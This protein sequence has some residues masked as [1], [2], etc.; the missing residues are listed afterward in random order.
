MYRAHHDAN[1]ATDK[2]LVGGGERAMASTNIT[3]TVDTVV[4]E[5]AIAKAKELIH[6]LEQANQL[7]CELYRFVPPPREEG[8]MCLEKS[9]C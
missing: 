9:D 1:C 8:A 7:I 5:E 6:L 3:A 2:L 4:T